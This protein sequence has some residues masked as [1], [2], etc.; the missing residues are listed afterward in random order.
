MECLDINCPGRVHGY[1]PKYDATWCVT[2]FVAHTC[3]L[4]SIPNDHSNM[5][6]NLIARLLYIEIVEGQ[7]MGVRGIQKNV[8]KHHLYTISYGKAWRA[9]QRALEMIFG[10]FRD[11]YDAI[12]RLL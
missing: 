6:S 11:T 3:E 5:S 8:K 10:S 1:V 7:A 4:A 9:K 12:V 2:D